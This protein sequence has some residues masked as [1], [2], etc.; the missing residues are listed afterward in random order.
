MEKK[1]SFI[2]YLK[3][4]KLLDLIKLLPSTCVILSLFF[5]FIGVMVIVCEV[6]P[7]NYPSLSTQIAWV[8]IW[9]I[10]S[11]KIALALEHSNN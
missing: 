4:T 10:A 2:R 9:A 8:I 5:A 7:V 11:F 1:E 6:S 3:E